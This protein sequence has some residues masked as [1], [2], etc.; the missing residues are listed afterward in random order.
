MAS[1]NKVIL[2]GNLTRDPQ[3]SY[4]P[5]QT[6]VVEFGLAVNRKFKKQD[7]SQGEEVC[8]VDCQMF[9]KRA[10]VINKY[11]K[12]GDP[13]FAE[14]RLKFDSWQGQD[15][16]KKSKLRVFVEN[17]EF[18]GKG[19]QGGGGG[20]HESTGGQDHYEMGGAHDDAGGDDIPF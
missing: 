7:G 19:G 3:L 9:G 17:F 2:I 14:G 1:Y 4:L 8:F 20:N 6:A 18:V 12:K 10:E 16:Q 15:G 5:S 13:I 11:F